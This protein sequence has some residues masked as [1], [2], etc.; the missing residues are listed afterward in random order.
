MPLQ[1]KLVTLVELEAIAASQ[2]FKAIA[3]VP[4]SYLE[5]GVDFIVNFGRARARRERMAR[6]P[7]EHVADSKQGPKAGEPTA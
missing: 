1:Q 5:K 2:T 4:A 7:A 3:D 6:R